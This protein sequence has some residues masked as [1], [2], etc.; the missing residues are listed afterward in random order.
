[1]LDPST[2]S[3]IS[4]GGV[5]VAIMLLLWLW[6]RP[7]SAESLWR[8]SGSGFLFTDTKAQHVGET[9]TVLVMESSRLSRQA[10]T[11]TKKES[12]NSAHLSSL[13]GLEEGGKHVAGGVRLQGEHVDGVPQLT[14]GRGDF[15]LGIEVG[16]DEQKSVGWMSE[17]RVGEMCG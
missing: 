8:D 14:K 5:L 1:M 3:R 13:F 2:C 15:P 9:V 17:F 7:A 10:E 6:A 11:T 4:H 16:V 12:R